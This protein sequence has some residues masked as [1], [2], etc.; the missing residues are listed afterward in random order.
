M[1]TLNV[2]NAVEGVDFTSLD[3][4]TITDGTVLFAQSDQWTVQGAEDT[5]SFLGTFGDYDANSVPHSG[6]I[7]EF[8]V[9]G[10]GGQQTRLSNLNFPVADFVAFVVANDVA[11][12]MQ[13]L[14]AGADVLFGSDLDDTYTGLGGNDEIGGHGG[15]DV[16]Y[17]GDGD[18]FINGGYLGNASNIPPGAPAD[19]AD[20]VYGEAGDDILRGQDGD[21][22]LSG[23]EGNDNLRGDLGA[24][25]LDGGI[26]NDD[27][28]GGNGQDRIYGGAGNDYLVGGADYDQFVFIGGATGSDTIA[29]F[30]NGV[31][32]IRFF[33]ASADDFSDLAIAD[34]GSGGVTITLPDG[35]VITLT[36]M[37][38]ADVD[39]SDFSFG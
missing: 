23:G 15:S 30:E 36:G 24:D 10:E 1:P 4:S 33:S 38:V 26:G 21:D 16:L 19:G 27:L 11:G 35:S 37:Q 29:D 14:L 32:K 2:F 8:T 17:G 20:T 39:A 12:L 18:D 22:V 31:D 9:F 25:T 3:L 6:T 7:T 34:N 13:A 28:S 5:I